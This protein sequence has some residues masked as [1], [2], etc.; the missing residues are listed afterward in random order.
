MRFLVYCQH[1]LGIGHL[2]R[3]Y[4]IL[5][6]LDNHQVTLVLGGPK[7]DIDPPNH[8]EVVQL[9]PLRMGEEFGGLLPV[10]PDQSLEQIKGERRQRLLQLF[11]ELCPDILLVEL[12]PFG[13]NAFRF[14]LEPLLDAAKDKCKVVCS[15]RDI[16]VERDNTAKF[17]QRVVERLNKWF[18][19]LLV[20]S[21]PEVIRL[22][23]TFS[24]MDDIDIPI[25]Y[26]GYIGQQLKPVLAE[27]ESPP[28]PASK[29][30]LIVASAG[31]GSVGFSLLKA[32]VKAHGLLT[33][34][35]R[36]QVFTGPYLEVSQYNQLQ[37]SA[38]PGAKVS[39]FTSSLPQ[40]LGSASLSVS[41]GGYNTTMN[42]LLA[43]CPALIFPFQQNQEQGLRA[44]KL[45]RHA[46][47]EILRPEDLQPQILAKR[48][49]DMLQEK[50][51]NNH[52]RLDGARV[53]GSLLTPP[54]GRR[55]ILIALGAYQQG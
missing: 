6:H 16:L 14:E 42:I 28:E 27:E 2:V 20:H 30:P 34:P 49:T 50:R 46:P 40:W 18:H 10:Y 4:E 43:G 3:I 26:T 44:D 12:F 1:V 29:Q 11:T 53:T 31:S 35:C 8:V 39:R 25:C 54:P 47:I 45:R 36:L 19:L 23:A 5:R 24:R 9:S 22:G 17:E 38:G 52:I 32:V 13:R 48:M 21:D 37:E 33:T 7:A 41:M 15:V 55:H 51:R